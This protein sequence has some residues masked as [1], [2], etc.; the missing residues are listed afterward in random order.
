[1]HSFAE[2]YLLTYRIVNGTK[3]HG[4]SSKGYNLFLYGPG[5][6]KDR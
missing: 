2:H 4:D 1:M 6:F 5:D 3:E